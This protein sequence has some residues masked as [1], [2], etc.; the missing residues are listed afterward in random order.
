MQRARER[1]WLRSRAGADNA[2]TTLRIDGRF[3]GAPAR[4]QG[5]YAGGLLHDSRPRRVWFRSAIPLDVDLDVQS[6]EETIRV[7]RA[8]TLVLESHPIG[9]LSA[10]LES[11][12]MAEA[13]R[14]RAWA[15]AEGFP[16]LIAPCYSCGTRAETL[17]TH[18]GRVG[19]GVWASPMTFPDWTATEG[20]VDAT[21]IWAVID[22]APGYPVAFGGAKPRFAFTGW[23][24]VDVRAPIEPGRPA[25]VVAEAGPWDGRKR[26]ARSA[27][28]TED[29]DL[30]ALSESLWIAPK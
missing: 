11:V 25:I 23:L 19:G 13:T 21:H 27:L 8:G 26:S 12:S 10:P 28:W 22:C 30:I 24:D 9:P 17:R 16:D 6:E 2:V 5:G 20:E 14:G 3:E 18:P 29:G 4:A 7:S 15:E 1:K